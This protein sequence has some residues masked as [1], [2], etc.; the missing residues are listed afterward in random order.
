MLNCLRRPTTHR[1]NN[2]WILASRAEACSHFRPPIMVESKYSIGESR[3]Y[4]ALIYS[5]PIWYYKSHQSA[6]LTWKN[7]S[8]ES[9]ILIS[10]SKLSYI[11]TMFNSEY[12]RLSNQRC[13]VLKFQPSKCF[14]FINKDATQ[15]SDNLQRPSVL[16]PSP[17]VSSQK[18][19]P[20]NTFPST[21]ALPVWSVNTNQI[22]VQY[23]SVN[24]NN[25]K[26]HHLTCCH[27]DKY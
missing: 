2:P 14:T 17:Q 19:F 12:T 18:I 10:K 9:D 4:K 22:A 3:N 1:E 23:K 13:R 26:L 20:H 27:F 16:L 5:R 8:K 24:D 11:C 21:L 15:V 6:P 25:I 7:S